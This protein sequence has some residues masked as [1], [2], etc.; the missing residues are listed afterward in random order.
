[1]QTILRRAAA[2][3]LVLAVS[4]CAGGGGTQVGMPTPGPGP[5]VPDATA[6]AAA[7]GALLAEQGATL[8]VTA[9]GGPSYSTVRRAAAVRTTQANVVCNGGYS[10]QD[11]PNG[12]TVHI[13]ISLY[14]DTQC[15][16][17]RQTAS[18]DRT[19][20]IDTGNLT[21]TIV[22]SDG[23]GHVT[24]TQTLDEFSF[25]SGGG[26]VRRSTTDAA[27]TSTTPFGR[28]VLF[29]TASAPQCTL[30]AVTDGP[31]FETGVVLGANTVPQTVAPG[32]SVTLAFTGSLSTAAPGTM[33]IA[34]TNFNPPSLQGGTPLATLTGSLTIAPGLNGPAAFSLS[35]DAG[36]THV[37]ASFASG[38]T[39]FTVSGGATATVNANGD[40]TIRYASGAT[41]RILDYRIA[42]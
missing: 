9:S 29:C 13:A 40:G 39:T 5:A 19:F 15:T 33:T 8:L 17:L 22:S 7:Q 6:R 21:G 12:Q 1:M 18:L 11:T 14:F 41:E 37:D 2:A 28:A 3:A 38:T 42:G 10:E 26:F 23:S 32:T 35:L 34:Q 24:A 25:A 4:A 20:G 27:G 16:S 36:S 30:V 31:S